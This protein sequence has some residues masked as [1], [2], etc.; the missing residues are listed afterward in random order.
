MTALIF[1]FNSEYSSIL[2]IPLIFSVMYIYYSFD[3]LI[4]L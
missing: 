3:Y 1:K 4:P 2:L